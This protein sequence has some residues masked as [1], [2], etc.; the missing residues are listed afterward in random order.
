MLWF[1]EGVLS[2]VEKFAFAQN[3]LES[4]KAKYVEGKIFLTDYLPLS[5]MSNLIPSPLMRTT[6]AKAFGIS[7]FKFE[8]PVAGILICLVWSAI[9]IGGSY[10]ILKKKDW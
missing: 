7:D 6:M 9:F 3:V 4:K 5:S 8:F 10:W 1:I 2:A